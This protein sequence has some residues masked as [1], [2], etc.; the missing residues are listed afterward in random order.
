MNI[1]VNK[2]SYLEDAVFKSD[3]SLVTETE[4]GAVGILKGNPLEATVGSSFLE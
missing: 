1:L 2:Q 4:T 3:I